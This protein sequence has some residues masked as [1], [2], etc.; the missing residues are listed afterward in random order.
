MLEPAPSLRHAWRVTPN[1]DLDAARQQDAPGRWHDAGQEAIY[2]SASPELAVLE[3]LA[4][5]H[6]SGRRRHWLCR[7]TLPPRH[8]AQ[9]VPVAGL[10]RGWQRRPRETRAI[11]AAWLAQGDGLALHVPSALVSEA[12]NVLLNPAHAA[13][14]RVSC[15]VL[16]PFRFDPRFARLRTP[17]RRS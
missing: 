10:A 13:A 16:T 12:T 17:P 14:L 15:E 7:L 9:R 11:G 2:A 3:A 4:H 1:P 8:R 6:E 5:L